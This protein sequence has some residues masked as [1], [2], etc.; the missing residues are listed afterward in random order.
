M[1]VGKLV[2]SQVMDHVP[3]YEFRRCVSRYQGERHVKQFRFLDQFFVMAFAQLTHRE[4]LR[5]INGCLHA[6]RSQL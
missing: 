3:L 2:F 5:D 6:Q 1:Y 4:S